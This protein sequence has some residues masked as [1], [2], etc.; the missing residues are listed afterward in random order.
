MPAHAGTARARHGQPRAASAP[1]LP[2]PGWA[3]SR[4]APA[5]PHTLQVR[6]RARRAS[7]SRLMYTEEPCKG[8]GR[9]NGGRGGRKTFRH[10]CEGGGRG[11]AAPST[12]LALEAAGAPDGAQVVH[13]GGLAVV[14]DG[15]QRAAHRAGAQPAAEEAL[16][17]RAGTAAA[18]QHQGRLHIGWRR[19]QVLAAL[20]QQLCGP[21]AAA[22]ARGRGQR[23]RL[24]VERCCRQG[25]L[26][27]AQLQAGAT[28]SRR[29]P[30]CTALQPRHRVVARLLPAARRSAA[31]PADS[32]QLLVAVRIPGGR[33]GC[34]CRACVSGRSSAP[35]GAAVWGP[36][37][38]DR[39]GRIR[40]LN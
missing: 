38:E 23:A 7:S 33:R 36:L 17:R 25:G 32:D 16:R 15:A 1:Q 26:A 29:A 24:T 35:A 30:C 39:R 11:R 19:D 8:W 34:R 27:P 14:G 40:Q 10:V 5:R 4:D 13:S 22:P 3:H 37:I 20:L 18:A 28:P 2:H 31:A 6:L 9:A 21:Q 12:H